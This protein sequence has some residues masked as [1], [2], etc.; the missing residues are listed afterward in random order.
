[1]QTPLNLTNLKF[2]LFSKMGGIKMGKNEERVK[3]IKII[4]NIVKNIDELERLE[5]I[6]KYAEYLYR[7]K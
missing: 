7:K 1:M 3:T 5:R 4:I 6:K 2:L